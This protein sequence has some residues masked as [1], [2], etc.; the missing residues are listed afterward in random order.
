M[1]GVL[2]DK[3]WAANPALC[4]GGADLVNSNKFA[5]SDEDVFHPT[6]SYKGRY[7]RYGIREH[8]MT[9]I[10]NGIAA[11]N[12]GTFVPLTAT[13]LIFYLYVS[14]HEYLG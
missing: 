13:F 1:N 2:I 14:L 9:S 8:A 5:Y 12:P 4:G 10:S 11:Y 7:I 6:V 3:L